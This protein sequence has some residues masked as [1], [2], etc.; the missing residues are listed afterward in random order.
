MEPSI[1]QIVARVEHPD[2]KPRRHHKR[3]HGPGDQPITEAKAAN[4]GATKPL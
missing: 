2:E 3:P 4:E 1:K